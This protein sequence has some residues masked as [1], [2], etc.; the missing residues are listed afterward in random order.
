M[1]QITRERQKDI[2]SKT[3]LTIADI[4]ELLPIGKNQSSKIFHQIEQEVLDDGKKLFTTRPKV[5]PTSYY[6]K[7]M[8]EERL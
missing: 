5:I 6:L 1:K 4:Y 7:Y 2:L 3:Y 8:K